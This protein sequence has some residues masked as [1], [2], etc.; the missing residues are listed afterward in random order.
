MKR[1]LLIFALLLGAVSSWGQTV[2]DQA[3]ILQA[4]IDLPE[5]QQHY[6]VNT[7]GTHQ[8]IYIMQHAVYFPV[9]IEVSKFGKK[10]VFLDKESMY[11]GNVKGF[12]LFEVFENTAGIAKINLLYN[13]KVQQGY[14]A[15]D[16][17]LELHKEDGNWNVF[18]SKLKWR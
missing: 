9:D 16:V 15:V 8:E 6:P 17:K 5:L 4:C 12:F 3:A 2:P 13:L 7:N 18:E 1:Y 14:R 10:P 11:N